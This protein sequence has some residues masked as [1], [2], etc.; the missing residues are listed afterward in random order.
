MK[1]PLA[2]AC[3]TLFFFSAVK[4][5]I[6]PF[7][8]LIDSVM[9]HHPKAEAI[10]LEQ[11]A[12]RMSALAGITGILP[13]ADYTGSWSR[14]ESIGSGNAAGIYA[15]GDERQSHSVTLSQPFF[16]PLK[17]GG[18][19]AAWQNH[20]LARLGEQTRLAALAFSVKS[21]YVDWAAALALVDVSQSSWEFAEAQLK[22]ALH[23]EELGTLSRIDRLFVE[24]NRAQAG[25][26]LEQ[27]RLA[28]ESARF[29]LESLLMREV[30]AE[31]RAEPLDRLPA[32]PEASLKPELRL[33]P[34]WQSLRRNLSAARAGMLSGS[35]SLFPSLSGFV[36]WSNESSDPFTWQSEYTNRVIGLSASWNLFRT[37]GNTLDNLAAWK[38]QRAAKNSLTG[39]ELDL[40]AKISSLREQ[41][42]STARQE[43]LARRS[44]EIAEANLQL[45]EQ[46]YDLGLLDATD[47]LAGQQ[48]L[49]SAESSLI[50]ARAAYL[51]AGWS[52]QELSGSW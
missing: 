30:P 7:E 22:R 15:E 25:I 39:G 47:L 33:T 48:N 4:A 21:A 37:G 45:L 8:A 32:A 26:Q 46:K 13:R 6:L 49:L 14:F 35:G 1:Q 19:L 16:S 5:E 51:K 31:F 12:A 41:L 23:R 11:S 9:Q 17:L 10:R 2:A 20:E 34:S 40:N 36:S 24:N 3:I 44:R 29:Q 52:L 50:K 38:R 18:A 42:A 27:A 43:A 28:E